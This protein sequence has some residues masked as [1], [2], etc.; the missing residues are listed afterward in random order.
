MKK[1]AIVVFGSI[2]MDLVAIARRMP[3]PG[4]T[5]SGER[6]FTAPGGKGGNQAVAAAKLGA[7]VKMVGRVGKDTFG[8]ALLADLHPGG[9]RS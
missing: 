8:P 5:I 9:L 3:Q 7:S 2:N 6:F 4:E 1:P